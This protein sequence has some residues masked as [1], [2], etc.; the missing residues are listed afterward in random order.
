MPHVPNHRE[1][2]R[3][4]AGP[5]SGGVLNKTDPTKPYKDKAIGLAANTLLGSGGAGAA[6]AAGAPMAAVGTPLMGALSNAGAMAS[7]LLS[8]PVLGPLALFGGLGKLFNIFSEGTT[9]V[10]DKANEVYQAVTDKEMKVGN[11]TYRQPKQLAGGTNMVAPMTLPEDPFN[12]MAMKLQEGASEIPPMQMPMSVQVPE[13]LPGPTMGGRIVNSPYNFVPPTDPKPNV[14]G[15][16]GGY[17][18][19]GPLAGKNPVKVE[20]KITATYG[21]GGP[22]VKSTEVPMMFSF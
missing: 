4:S 17:Q 3:V 13:G 14:P 6:T 16:L 8:A 15:V 1:D 19:G 21:E 2:R 9:N 7:G 18:F 11:R 22:D 12:N 20:Q 10:E 5:V